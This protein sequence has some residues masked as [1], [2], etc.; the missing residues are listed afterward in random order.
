MRTAFPFILVTAREAGDPCV[1]PI[2]RLTSVDRFATLGYVEEM[3]AVTGRDPVSRRL[4]Q[5]LYVALLARLIQGLRPGH[6]ALPAK[7][8]WMERCCEMIDIYFSKMDFSVTWLA[9]ELECTPDHV[10]R[11][12]RAHTGHRVMEIV[13]RRRIDHARRLLQD[14]DMN[15]A[16]IAWTCGFSQTSYFDRIFKTLTGSS[17]KNFRRGPFAPASIRAVESPRSAR[18]GRYASEIY[19]D[20]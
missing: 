7:H 14:S 2:D 11:R 17:P 3:A 5:G 10:S 12:Y 9:R 15:I 16:E 18:K 20:W 8:D 13:H 19:F 6:H 4:R 1:C